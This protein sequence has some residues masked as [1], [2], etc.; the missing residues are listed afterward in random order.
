M[1]PSLKLAAKRIGRLIGRKSTTASGVDMPDT[2]MPALITPDEAAFCEESAAAF[3]GKAGAIV[4]LGCWLGGT[5]VALARGLMKIENA[6]K[7]DTVLGLDLFLWEQWMPA[8]VAYCVY[9]PGDSFLPEARRLTRDHGGGKI[10]LIH[11]DLTTYDWTGGPIKIL[12]VDAMK[13]ETLT[14]RIGK[15]FYPSLR[16]GALLIHQDFK[17]FHTSW[18]HLL[19]FALREYFRLH[20]IVPNSSTVAFEVVKAIPA[21]AVARAMKFDTLSDDEIDECFRYSI[22]LT[23]RNDCVNIVAA[24]ITHYLHLG[25]QDRARKTLDAYRARGLAEEG[26][27]ATVS[28]RLGITK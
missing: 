1:F 4:D 5:S 8:G 9:Q 3:V 21:E 24:H 22:E 16:T 7:K 17:H 6:A 26:E 25:R 13:S 18:I 23:G 28:K 10:E 12:L 19:Q 2:Q 11:A 14:R 27:L 15:S 20:R